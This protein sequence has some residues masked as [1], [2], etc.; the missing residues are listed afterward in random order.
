L[1]QMLDKYAQ[2]LAACQSGPITAEQLADVTAT[3]QAV[4]LDHLRTE[5]P[6][7]IHESLEGVERISQ[8]IKSMKAFCHPGSA[9]QKVNI[10]EAIQSTVVISRNEWKYTAEVVTEFDSALPPVSCYVGEFNQAILNLLVNAAHAIESGKR[11]TDTDK[12]LIKISTC[13]DGAWIEVRINDTGTG[14]PEELRERIFEPFFTT[15]EV[16]KGTGQGLAIVHAVL[17]EKHGGTIRVESEVGQGTTFILRI[18]IDA[19]DRE[20]VETLQ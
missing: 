10:N 2:F 3:A 20:L 11:A 15:K 12:G 8:I 1:N 6:E 7:A 14:I 13:S 19:T 5:I 9:K 17:V 4:R 16:G 18:P